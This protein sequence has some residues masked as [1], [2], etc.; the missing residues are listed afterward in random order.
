V[1]TTDVVGPVDGPGPAG[2][3]EDGAQ[4][5]TSAHATS[6]DTIHERFM[7]VTP[8]LGPLSAARRAAPSPE[9]PF[10]IACP[11]RYLVPDL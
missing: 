10:V 1:G 8:G 7:S 11:V 5:A 3:G 9:N 4:P 6:N 2:G